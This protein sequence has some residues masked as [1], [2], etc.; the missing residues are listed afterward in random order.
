MKITAGSQHSIIKVQAVMIRMEL[1]GCRMK[2]DFF[3]TTKAFFVVPVLR[4]DKQIKRM[5]SLQLRVIWT[6]DPIV[7]PGQ[8]VSFRLLV[9]L[10][11]NK[12]K[13]VSEI[14]IIYL[15]AVSI[16]ELTQLRT[17]DEHF[18]LSF[19]NIYWHK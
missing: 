4:S 13:V 8:R 15:A 1:N 16:H 7:A 3:F 9:R 19:G 14:K 18:L 2:F 17:K 12:G 11:G 10:N 6:H 5:D